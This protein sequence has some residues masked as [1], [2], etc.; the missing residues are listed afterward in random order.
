MLR[1]Q[2]QYDRFVF[3]RISYLTS[4]EEET[5]ISLD[6]LVDGETY[7]TNTT[8]SALVRIAVQLRKHGCSCILRSSSSTTQ[9]P[10]AQLSWFTQRGHASLKKGNGR[11]GNHDWPVNRVRGIHMVRLPY[12]SNGCADQV[13]LMPCPF[14]LLRR[15]GHLC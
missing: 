9:A 5:L 6:Q 11:A 3:G 10:R 14:C 13:L 2:W 8:F 12:A 1:S 7:Y 15:W 4:R